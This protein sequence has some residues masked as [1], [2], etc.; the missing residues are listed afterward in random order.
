MA[1]CPERLTGL[2]LHSRAMN[3]NS[4][5]GLA[6]L[7]IVLVVVGA[8]LKFALT[9]HSRGFNVHKVGDILLV[10]GVLLAIFSLAIVVRGTRSRT[11]A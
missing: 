1:R 9:V 11:T 5:I 8:I 10:V 4:G 3:R 7:G 6:S 2:G